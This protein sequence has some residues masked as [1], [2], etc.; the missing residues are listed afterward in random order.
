MEAVHAEDT[1]RI[2][3]CKLFPSKAA[4]ILSIATAGDFLNWNPHLHALA[5]SGTFRDDGSFEP[6]VLVQ[7]NILRE[8][9]EAEVFRL[10]VRKGLIGS[11]LAGKMRSWPH[12]GFHVHVGPAVTDIRDAA[13]IGLYIVRPSASAGRLQLADDAGW[14]K[15][16][17]KGSLPHPYA[18]SLFEP[19]A[20]VFDSLDWIARLTSHIPDKGAQTIHYYGAC[21]NVSRGKRRKA[22]RSTG[23]Q[24]QTAKTGRADEPDS[25]WLK[26]RRK[27]WAALIKLIYE[28]DPLL[29][30]KCKQPMPVI[31]F[32]REGAVIDKILDHLQYRFDVS[33]LPPRAPPSSL[34][35][36]AEHYTWD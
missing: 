21:S 23:S 33:P 16:L 2:D 20:E 9:F 18:D 11:E 5:V 35:T 22:Q 31:A 1:G 17:A 25:D 24:P 27:S 28:V 8:L 12:S 26:E 15:Y 29:C 7:E 32:I 19:N 6:A 14:L 36:D 10:L 3:G 34:P 30:P 13:R 4:A